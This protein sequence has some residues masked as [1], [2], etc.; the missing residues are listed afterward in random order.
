VGVRRPPP[1]AEGL[2]LRRGVKECAEVLAGLLVEQ[3]FRRLDAELRGVCRDE[4]RE[5][6][7]ALTSWLELG[8]LAAD[9]RVDGA[10]G[11]PDFVGVA[12]GVAA[13]ALQL[14]RKRRDGLVPAGA[15]E[16]RA[17]P[18][19][20]EVL[21]REERAPARRAGGRRNE[22]VQEERALRCEAVLCIGTCSVGTGAAGW[23]R[24]WQRSISAQRTHEVRCA[25]ELVEVPVAVIWSVRRGIPPP[26]LGIHV[27]HSRSS[28]SER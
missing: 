18:T 15:L 13:L 2:V 20:K 21:A 1:V 17:Q 5:E 16:D 10:A 19:L 14:E 8:A 4:M 22:R 28:I 12:D 26:V 25:N 9:G 6:G 3:L 23:A 27:P 7:V 24:A 11:R